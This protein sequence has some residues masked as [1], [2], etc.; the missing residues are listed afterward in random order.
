MTDTTPAPL[1]DY[2]TEFQF[3]VFPEGHEY[4]DIAAETVK[5]VKRGDGRW[6]VL[7][8]TH[9]YDADGNPEYESIPS[10]RTDEFKQ[11]FRHD[12]ATAVRLAREVVVPLE[13]ERWERLL[14]RRSERKAAQAPADF[15]IEWGDT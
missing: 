2:A 6:A 14:A 15:G 9:C 5:V 10:E 11:R 4:W 1:I 12:L 7:D 13:R 8:R 3:P